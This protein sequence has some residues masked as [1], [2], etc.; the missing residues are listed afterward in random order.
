MKLSLM[1]A[2]NTMEAVYDEAFD[3]ASILEKM[4]SKEILDRTAL[5]NVGM[6]HC[7]S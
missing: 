4:I 5:G 1:V 2:R 7:N 3:N 6:R